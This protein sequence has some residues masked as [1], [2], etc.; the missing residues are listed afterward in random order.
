[1]NFPFVSIIIPCR[2]ERNF[3]EKCLESILGQDYDR[4]RLEVLVLDGIS[5][6]GTNTIVNK[7]STKY[8]FIRVLENPGK[9]VSKA[10]NIGIRN[11]RGEAILKMDAHCTYEKDYI[12][13]CVRYLDEYAADNAGGIC[14]TLPS[15][16]TL[17][18][19]SVALALSHPFGVGNSY[20]RI[21]SREP[22]FVDTVPF[23]CYRKEVFEKI[24]FFDEE[25]IRNQDDEFN[26]RLIKKGGKVLLAPEIVSYY[27]ARDSLSK[28][29]RM[30]FQYGYFKPLVARKVGGVFTWRQLVPALFV[31]S[32]LASAALSVV[33]KPFLWVL[34]SILSFYVLTNL[35]VSFDIALKKGLK[36]FFALPIVFS[37]LHVSYGIGYLMGIWDFLIVRKNRQRKIEDVPL[38]R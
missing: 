22:K 21:G 33:G 1:M 10:M 24:G 5:E 26:L 36:Y 23:G 20:F 15:S 38:T 2:N 4:N 29:L 14:I 27:Y 28:L 37:T 31:G 34:L 32:V 13:K 25:L 9:I 8:P 19:E 12:S 30:C 6:D 17:V 18:A 7:Y 35:A 11:A 3:I 16:N